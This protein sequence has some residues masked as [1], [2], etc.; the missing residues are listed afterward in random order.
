MRTIVTC[1]YGYPELC[2]KPATRQCGAKDYPYPMFSCE[3]HARLMH[4]YPSE[5]LKGSWYYDDSTHKVENEFHS[6]S[7]HP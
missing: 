7:T 4:A 1:E 2:G 6:L 5:P 3:A